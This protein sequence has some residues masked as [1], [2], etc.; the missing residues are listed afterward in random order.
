MKRTIFTSLLAL[1]ACAALIAQSA[2]KGQAGPKQ[3]APKSKAEADA[4]TA[5][6][7]AAQAG[8][9]DQIIKNGDELITKFADTDYKETAL[10][11]MADA[12][13]NKR[14][15]AKAEIYAEQALAANPKSY[16]ASI[17]LAEVIVQ[18]T[19]ENDLDREEKLGKAEKHAKDAV[20]FSKD[21][22]KPNPQITDEQWA[23]FKKGIVARAHSSMGLAALVRK[24]YDV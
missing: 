8:N 6:F 22:P 2:P 20:D 7:Q 5:L 15:N 18:G 11:M 21:A 19:R 13:Q 10:Y 3:P 24:K 17:L 23:E 1:A 9:P 12:Y 16:Q 14:D 4:L